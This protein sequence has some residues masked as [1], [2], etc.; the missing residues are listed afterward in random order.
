VIAD[1][2]HDGFAG[3]LVVV[4]HHDDFRRHALL[5]EHTLDGL[6]QWAGPSISRND[7]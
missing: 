3:T 2:T 4:V 5:R 7:H 6:P 1:G